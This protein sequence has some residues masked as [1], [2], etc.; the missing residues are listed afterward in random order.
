LNLDENQ[1]NSLPESLANLSYF[2]LNLRDNRFDS[3]SDSITEWMAN[4][5]EM[6][7]VVQFIARVDGSK[8]DTPELQKI[9]SEKDPEYEDLHGLLKFK[10][11][12][13]KS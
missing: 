4:L 10:L 1:L 13:W 9:L 6:R 12:D 5:K 11:K 3:F 7:M 2:Y 8:L